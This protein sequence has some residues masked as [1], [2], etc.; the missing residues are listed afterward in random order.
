MERFKPGFVYERRSRH[1]FGSTSF[2]PPF[3][4]DL[5]PNPAPASTTLRRSTRASQPPNWYGFFS[6]VSLVATLSL[7]K[8]PLVTN[9]PWNV[10]VSKL[11]CN[12]NFKHLRR[13][14]LGILF[15]VLPQSNLLGVNVTP[16]SRGSVDYPS[17]RGI[18]VDVGLPDATSEKRAGSPLYGELYPNTSPA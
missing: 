13:I 12:Q 14:T 18:Q 16:H 5:A 9:R 15:L 10:C 2:V 1:E 4:L 6:H 11:Q 17:T 8:F 3:D 7:F